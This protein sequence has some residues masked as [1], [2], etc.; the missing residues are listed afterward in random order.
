M[1][2]MVKEKKFNVAELADAIGINRFELNA[3]VQVGEVKIIEDIT[4]TGLLR[5]YKKHF[6]GEPK[7]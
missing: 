7:W 1:T 3:L 4:K 2:K 6:G 5:K